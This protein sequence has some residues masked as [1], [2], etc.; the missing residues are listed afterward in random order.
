M[1]QSITTFLM[2]DGTAEEAM[3]FYVSLFAGSTFL[4]IDRWAAGEPGREGAIKRG[5]FSVGG[6]EMIAFDSPGQHAFTFT[7]SMSLFV[8]CEGEAE[9]D[10]VY[11]RLSDGGELLMP[12]DNYGFSRKFAWVNERSGVSRQLNWTWISGT[13]VRERRPWRAGHCEPA[14]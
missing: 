3:Q 7:P 12:L 13:L 14:T 5:A 4:R 1:A 9:L 6:H 11:A 10:T 8:E 2:F